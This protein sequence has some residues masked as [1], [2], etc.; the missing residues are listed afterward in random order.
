MRLLK[1]MADEQNRTALQAKLK[2]SGRAN[3]LK[4]YLEPSLKAGLI[5]MTIP[6]KPKSRLQKY[7]LTDKGRTL[8]GR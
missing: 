3:F 5:E 6:D 1:V 8:I 7:R 2:L 4:L